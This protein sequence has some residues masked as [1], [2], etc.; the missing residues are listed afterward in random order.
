MLQLSDSEASAGL[1]IEAGDMQV[2][3]P[4]FHSPAQDELVDVLT[5]AVAKLNIDWPQERV[6]AQPASKLDG[7]FFKKR[8][9]PSCRGLPFFPD[10]HNELCKS[11]GKPFSA[12]LSNPP[13]L[14]FGCVIGASEKGYGKMPRIEEALAS[15]LSPD[16]ASSLK[17]PVLPSKPCS[18]SLAALAPQQRLARAAS[19]ATRAPPQGD[20]QQRR[21]S[22]QKASK[23]KGDLRAVLEAR[24]SSAK[25]S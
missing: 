16:A 20:W 6:E 25:R 19:A 12:R 18:I 11:W 10:L 17:T 24:K 4:P 14:D 8:V 15:Y 3:D 9:Q 7:R 23:P 13:V 21:R 1:S 2:D 5:R 22:Q